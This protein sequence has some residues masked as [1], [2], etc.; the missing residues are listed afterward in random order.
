MVI[1]GGCARVISVKARE[2]AAANSRPR[3]KGERLLR[4][5][6]C[7]QDSCRSQRLCSA[8]RI[9]HVIPGALHARLALLS[10]PCHS[11]GSGGMLPAEHNL[12]LRG[13]A[14]G[15]IEARGETHLLIGPRLLGAGY[16][17]IRVRRRGCRSP[18]RRWSRTSAPP[19]TPPCLHAGTP[20]PPQA[21]TVRPSTK[22]PSSLRRQH[23]AASFHTWSAMISGSGRPVATAAEQQPHLAALLQCCCEPHSGRGRTAQPGCNGHTRSCLARVSTAQRV[24]G[25]ALC[26]CL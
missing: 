1:Q 15:T 7:C 2:A 8:T 18:G 11:S 4:S 5:C 13:P 26:F 10:R 17:R 14:A 20:K 23:T 25:T 24:Q 9:Q 19:P 12:V 3:R 21:P 6:C 16:F 22:S